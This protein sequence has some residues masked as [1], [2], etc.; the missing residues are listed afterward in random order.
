[1]EAERALAK[2]HALRCFASFKGKGAL[3]LNLNFYNT[4]MPDKTIL[5]SYFFYKFVVIIL[6]VSLDED[7]DD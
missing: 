3:R 4:K 5:K 6:A 2:N 1:V 7:E